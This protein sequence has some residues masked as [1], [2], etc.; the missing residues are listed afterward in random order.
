MVKFKEGN[1]KLKNVK[2]FKEL[3]FEKGMFLL[4]CPILFKIGSYGR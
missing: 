2:E 4:S 3:A 1:I